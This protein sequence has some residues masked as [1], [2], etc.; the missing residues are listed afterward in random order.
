[1]FELSHC[2]TPAL[3]RCCFIC[4]LQSSFPSL[5]ALKSMFLPSVKTGVA[6]FKVKPWAK[7]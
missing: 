5:L 7:K 3:G 6:K 1:M 4:L 2:L